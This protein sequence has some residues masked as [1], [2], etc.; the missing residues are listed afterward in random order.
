MSQAEQILCNFEANETHGGATCP[1]CQKRNS[2]KSKGV[3]IVADANS[4][5]EHFEEVAPVESCSDQLSI[6]FVA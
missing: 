5:C 1:Y 4:K 2:L 6:I 3:W